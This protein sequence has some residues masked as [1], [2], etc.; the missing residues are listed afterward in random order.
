M[1]VGLARTTFLRPMAVLVLVS[2]PVP[3]GV[4]HETA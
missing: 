1:G 3:E 2:G 4:G